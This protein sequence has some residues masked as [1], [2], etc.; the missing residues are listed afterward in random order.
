MYGFHNLFLKVAAEGI[1]PS[2]HN[3]PDLQSGE[4]TTSVQYCHLQPVYLFGWWAA[5]PC[6]DSIWRSHKRLSFQ[7]T[8]NLASQTVVVYYF[9]QCILGELYC[10]VAGLGI[11]PSWLAYEASKIAKTSHPHLII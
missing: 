6:G 2:R 4:P 5:L 8:D 9:T 11:E 1:E 10:Q 3:E 7:D